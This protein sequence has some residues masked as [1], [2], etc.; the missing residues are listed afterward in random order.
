LD[1]DNGGDVVG[2]GIAFKLVYGGWFFAFSFWIVI[3]WEV[4]PVSGCLDKVIVI[5]ADAV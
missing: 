1:A 2:W 3:F 5:F 4:V